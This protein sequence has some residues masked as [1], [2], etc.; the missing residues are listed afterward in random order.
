MGNAGF[1]R[2][3]AIA[4]FAALML[5]LLAG[6]ETA[7]ATGKS[8]FTGGLGPEEEQKL[9][10][11]EHPKILK[12]FGGD[13]QEDPELSAYITS[14][15]NLLARTSE[16]PNLNFTFTVLDTPIVNA[17]ALPGGYI[18]ITRG[19]LALAENEAEVAG[20]LA[21]EIGHVTAR[22]SAERYGNTVLA[23]AATTLL[24]V[25]VGGPA[26]QAAGG[27]AALA[28]QSYS[29][30]QEFEA[31][32][33]GVRYLSRAGYDPQG[34]SSFLGKLQAHGRLEAELRGQPGKADEFDIM[35]THPRTADRIERAIKAANTKAVA[36]PIVAQDIYYGKIDGMLYGDDP[37]QG[38][39]RG[40]EF[41]HPDLLFA[42]EV[43]SGFR[44]FNSSKAVLALGPEGSQIKFDREPKPSS[45]SMTGYLTEIWLPRAGLKDV[46]A[47]EINGLPAATGQ[48][49]IRSRQ[50]GQF[51]VRVVAIRTGPSTIYRFPFVTPP[52]QTAALSEGLRR[53]T[54]SFRR[55]SDS[56]AAELRPQRIKIHRVRRGESIASL[57]RKMPFSDF[58]QERFLTLNGMEKGETLK[59]GQKV[60]LITE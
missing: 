50:G 40:Q 57:A 22:H 33:L 9:G 46:E 32:T 5:P 3:L 18:Y 1:L 35:Q 11:Q 19:L 41:L 10:L 36:D 27:G 49:R 37:S 14:I 53:T 16:L 44:L 23:G 25:L 42:F 24:G 56:E 15:G 39:I 34:M 45:G 55:L 26:A 52:S 13:Y 43:P 20:V 29:R 2:R 31:D 21:H 60:K 59:A 4:A 8:I 47:L 28:L 17:F 6:C 48:A 30:D 51:D 38:F 58:R 54:Y 12:E 7:P